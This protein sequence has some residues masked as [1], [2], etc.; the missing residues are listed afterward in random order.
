MLQDLKKKNN[1]K[2]GQSELSLVKKHT[3]EA[4]TWFSTV[5]GIHATSL[6]LSL[7]KHH[8]QIHALINMV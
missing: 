5:K 6:K 7:L 4:I 3:A 2:T 8:V 1:I